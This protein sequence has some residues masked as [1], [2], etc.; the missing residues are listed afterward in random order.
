MRRF[1]LGKY[2]RIVVLFFL[3]AFAFVCAR[4]A[5]GAWLKSSVTERCEVSEIRYIFKGGAIKLLLE[6]EKKESP[7]LIFL[8]GGPCSP[9]PFGFGAR[10]VFPEFSKDFICVYWDQPGCGADYDS[11][12]VGHSPDLYVEL[13]LDIIKDLR[14][15]FPKNKIY[16]FGI[17]WGALLS[18]KLAAKY[19]DR[20]DGVV[21]Y[22]QPLSKAGRTPDALE[23][24]QNAALSEEDREAFNESKDSEKWE[25]IMRLYGLL[26]EYVPTG[27]VDGASYGRVYSAFLWELISPD[28]SPREAYLAAFSRAKPQVYKD[29]LPS[30]FLCD[31]SKELSNVK[32]PY[33]VVQGDKDVLTSF[34]NIRAFIDACGNPNLTL[35]TVENC[36]HIPSDAAFAAIIDE[37]SKIRK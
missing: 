26:E 7:I 23:R 31:L 35:R 25:D 12:M 14:K 11:S 27:T 15:D 13:C 33:A 4:M 34:E 19:P 8:H 28:Y 18:A 1:A 32:I 2:A 24:L 9:I 17:S 36:A 29:L 20:V 10:G 21:A 37:L 3:L 22:A 30:I 6:G 5:Y 16:V